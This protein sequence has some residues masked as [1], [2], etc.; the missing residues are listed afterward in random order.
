MDY[1]AEIFDRMQL[2][3]HETGFNDH[4]IHCEIR[5]AGGLD[6]TRLRRAVRLSLA[7]IPI[8]ATRYRA[9][10][11]RPAW[12]SLPES[13]L[14]RAFAVA[15]DEAVF[16]SEKTYRI[17]E[18]EGPQVRLCLLRG[19]RGALALTMNHMIADGAGFKEYLYFLCECYARAGEGAGESEGES[20]GER[21][22]AGSSPAMRIDGDRGITD[23]MRAFGAGAK[24]R[25]ALTQG[26]DSNR[27]GK[28]AFPF[29]EGGELHPFIATR[30]ISR[31]KVAGLKAYC[32]ARGATL[33]DAALAAYYRVLART[34]GRAALEGLEVPIMIDMR[35]YLPSRSFAVL[36]NLA[37]TAI[38]RLRQS[39]GE[40][41]EETLAKAK[42]LMDALKSRNIG[43]GG[44]LKLSLL[45]SL[46]G[47]RAAESLLRR[48]LRHPLLCMTNLGEID[49]K[50][51]VFAGS[52]V[53]SAYVCGSIKYKPHF[54]L[55]LSGFDGTIT[56]SSNLYGSEEDRNRVDV[57]LA[58][59]EREFP[60]A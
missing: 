14:E 2:L 24:I 47:G 54:Q 29:D 55:A 34:I 5:L 13:D 56:L 1:R 21:A 28:L 10:S 23:L 8:L 12:E 57:F 20:E 22:C 44:Y 15:D 45:F 33:N 50:R 31:E 32:R 49:A 25:A 6:E 3:Y 48:G 46:F 41:F 35:R 39:E 38:T 43:L 30:L 36:R 9:Q 17:R 4:Q 59:V 52:R 53:A 37:S 19:E 26:A 40:G 18:E 27:T 42:A 11:G 60:C 7:S 51:L 16:E 58:R